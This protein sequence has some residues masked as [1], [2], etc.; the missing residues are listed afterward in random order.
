MVFVALIFV[1]LQLRGG[2][3]TWPPP[4]VN[5]LEPV[6]PT[7]MTLALIVSGFLLRRGVRAVKRDDN[8]TFRANW[9]TAIILGVIFIVVMALEWVTVPYSGQYSD[10]FRLMVGFH[11]LHALVIGIFLVRVYRKAGDY[12]AVNF[13]PVEGGASLWYFVVIAWLLFY[14]VLYVI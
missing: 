7:A 3:P 9:R 10:L 2:A 12:N 11:G 6:I 13:W 5:Q 8:D 4:G 14:A 1:N